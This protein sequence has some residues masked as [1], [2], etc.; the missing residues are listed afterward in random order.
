[1]SQRNGNSDHQPRHTWVG[2]RFSRALTLRERRLLHIVVEDKHM[3]PIP[4]PAVKNAHT[5]FWFYL[6]DTGGFDADQVC[7]GTV[8]WVGANVPDAECQYN[9]V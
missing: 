6:A 1:M 5:E 3:L 2:F 4:D 7:R 9:I 8:A